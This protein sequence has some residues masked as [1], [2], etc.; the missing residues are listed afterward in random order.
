MQVQVDGKVL[1]LPCDYSEIEALG[2][3]MDLSVYESEEDYTLE[4]NYYAMTTVKTVNKDGDVLK[5]GFINN[6]DAAKKFNECQ[7][8]EIKA[9]WNLREGAPDIVLPGGITWGTPLEEVETGSFQK[10]KLNIYT[11]DSEGKYDGV[12]NIDITCQG[13]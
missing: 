12:A 9:E 2:Y 4:P 11:D 10:I 7:V 6:G 5:L 1:T 3:T 8:Y 13:E